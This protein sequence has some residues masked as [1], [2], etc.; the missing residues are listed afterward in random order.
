MKLN[1]VKLNILEILG[2]FGLTAG[3]LIQIIKM[4]K[5][6]KIL[7]EKKT[8]DSNIQIKVE[9]CENVISITEPVLRLLKNKKILLNIHYY[10]HQ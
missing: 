5:G 2:F 8:D 7:D 1:R 9:N 3:S 4:T 6:N 10:H